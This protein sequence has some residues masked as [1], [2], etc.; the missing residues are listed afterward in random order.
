LAPAQVLALPQ[1]LP[2]ALG[3]RVPTVRALLP[4]AGKAFFSALA[5]LLL[6]EVILISQF[7]SLSQVLPLRWIS[8]SLLPVSVLAYGVVSLLT[9]AS[10][11]ELPPLLSRSGL[12]IS[13]VLEMMPQMFRFPRIDRAGVLR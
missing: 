5:C 6:L 3:R 9:T 11:C 10:A 7:S 12:E 4:R 1:A 2:E 8:F 13:L